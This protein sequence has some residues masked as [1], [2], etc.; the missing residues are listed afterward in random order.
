MKYN[1]HK[2]EEPFLDSVNTKYEVNTVALI[3]EWLDTSIAIRHDV[4]AEI[5]Q[6]PVLTVSLSE[7]GFEKVYQ[8]TTILS[9][10][11]LNLKKDI[12]A[13]LGFMLYTGKP[14]DMPP[15]FS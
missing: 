1:G 15:Q 2:P 9:L 12:P 10:Y 3:D 13:E 6:T 11:N 5:W 7:G 14:E 8:G 4:P